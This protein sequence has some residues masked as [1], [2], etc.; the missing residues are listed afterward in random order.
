MTRLALALLGSLM[1]A[2]GVVWAIGPVRLLAGL[3]AVPVAW[4]I[5][6]VMVLARR[7]G[8]SGDR[9]ASVGV[10]SLVGVR[11]ASL[12]RAGSPSP[13]RALSFSPLSDAERHPAGTGIFP[14]YWK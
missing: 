4:A 7:Q 13:M 9:R 10:R 8:L 14:V 11:S 2:I 12:T 3:V 1:I 6:L 5:V